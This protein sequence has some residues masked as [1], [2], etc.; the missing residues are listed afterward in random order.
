[1]PPRNCLL[2]C[3]ILLTTP[4]VTGFG[5]MQGATQ[6][7]A[8]PG[9]EVHFKLYVFGTNESVKVT[10]MDA[11]SDWH[12]NVDREQVD[13]PVDQGFRYVT[14]ANGYQKAVP[15]TVSATLSHNATPGTHPITVVLT[16][17]RTRAAE[18]N[19]VAVRQLQDIQFTVAV[20]GDTTDTAPVESSHTDTSG[21]GLTITAPDSTGA[22]QSQSAPTGAV[23]RSIG[24]T[25]LFLLVLFEITWGIVLVYL[26][27]R[28]R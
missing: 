9:N 28:R 1:M 16:G 20:T 14:A 10:R 2:L 19:T 13:F 8:D 6:A 7:P 25:P 18:T 21:G 12:V 26:V 24:E 5:Y 27:R 11:P 4:A 23:T 22:N 3:F 15:I 17:E